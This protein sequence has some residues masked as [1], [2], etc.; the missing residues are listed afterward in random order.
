MNNNGSI[1]ISIVFL[2]LVV[3]LAFTLL[4]ITIFHNQIQGARMEKIRSTGQM[5]EELIYYLHLFR[6]RIYAENINQFTE[7]ENDYFNSDHFP[8]APSVNAPNILIKNSFSHYKRWK[9]GYTIVNITN[10]V[11]LTSTDNNFKLRAVLFIRLLIGKIPVTLFPFFLNNTSSTQNNTFLKKNR[12][13][14]NQKDIISANHVEADPGTTQFLADSL[15][16]GDSALTW[17]GMREKFGLEP[18]DDP[19]SE[20]IHRVAEGDTISCIFI[21][22]NINALTFSTDG[23]IQMFTVVKNNIPHHFS[24]VPGQPVFTGWEGNG[25]EPLYFKERIV[26]NGNIWKLSQKGDAA[27]SENSDITLYASGQVVIK[28]SLQTKFLSVKKIKSTNLTLVCT[29]EDLFNSDNGGERGVVVD[30]TEETDIRVSVI[31]DG[32][33]ENKTNQLN[34]YGSIFCGGLNNQ[35]KIDITPASSGS[36]TLPFFRTQDYKCISHFR[37]NAI[38]D[39]QD[40]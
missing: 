33:F 21:Q 9:P 38:E 6:T 31:T 17:R 14:V 37:I 32:T 5:T 3:F 27:F 10:T 4:H 34:V 36:T 20:G 13:T 11:N 7:P 8:D 29:N 39:V 1:I 15:E 22:G 35:G 30:C 25:E 26:V 2:I 19:I 12:V 18:S 40:E 24:Y 28:T 16:I 23:H